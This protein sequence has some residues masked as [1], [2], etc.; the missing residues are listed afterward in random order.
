MFDFRNASAILGMVGSFG[1][2]VAKGMPTLRASLFAA[3]AGAGSAFSASTMETLGVAI[4]R[5]GAVTM[6]KALVPGTLAVAL[7]S[8]DGLALRVTALGG[9]S[10]SVSEAA[11]EAVKRVP[12]R[13]ALVGV[14]RSTAQGAIA[15]ALVDGVIAAVRAG[16]AIRAGEMTFAEG[17][18]FTGKRIARGAAVGGVGVLAAGAASA[19]IA[20]TGLTFGAPVVVPVVTMIAV[21]ALVGNQIDRFIAEPAKS[22]PS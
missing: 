17:A 4:A 10:A 9:V 16:Q 21:G 8:K 19:A 1:A 14:G 2:V 6:V 12:V 15:G 20:A 13:Q 11:I 22:L 18:A 5:P 3:R 7:K